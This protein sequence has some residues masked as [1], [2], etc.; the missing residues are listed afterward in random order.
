VVTASYSSGGGGSAA[1]C[2]AGCAVLVAGFPGE[3]WFWQILI[4]VLVRAIQVPVGVNLHV[5]PAAGRH[6]IQVPGIVP[7][8]IQV[9]KTFTLSIPNSQ[10][11]KAKR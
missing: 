5:K 1:A 2:A 8:E 7:R 10:P 11:K 4:F 6:S 3:P 9:R